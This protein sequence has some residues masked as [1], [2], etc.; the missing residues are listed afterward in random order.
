[1]WVR[2]LIPA[3]DGPAYCILCTT[4]FSNILKSLLAQPHTATAHSVLISQPHNFFKFFKISIN[5]KSSSKLHN[6]LNILCVFFSIT[7]LFWR[8]VQLPARTVLLLSHTALLVSHT[9]LRIAYRT[10]PVTYR[11]AP[12][13]YCI[14]ISWLHPLFLYLDTISK[15]AGSRVRTRCVC[16]IKYRTRFHMLWNINISAVYNARH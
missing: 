10:A 3:Y 2:T 5:W 4:L 9:V 8:T 11:T 1:M 14:P 6:L 7:S 16:V 13:V 15:V 12:V